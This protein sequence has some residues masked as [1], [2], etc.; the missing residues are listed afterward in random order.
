[1]SILIQNG[2]LVLPTGP[3]QADL[4]VA[5]G[6]IAELGPGL[7]PGASRVIDA[8]ERLVFPGFI[9]T[10]THFEMN[11]GFPNE[12]ADDWYTGTRAALA[13]GTTTVLDFAEPER[14]A[15]LASALETW[16]G[17]ADGA[18]CCNYGFHMTVK[19]WSP[20]I[21][22]EL[23]EMTA[24]GVTSYKV[25]LA[26][27]NLRL[28]DAAAY[29]VVKAVGAEGGVVGCHCENGD[30]VTEGIRAQQ[31]AGNLS[32]AA[33][34]LSRPPAVEAEAVGRWLT[35]AELAGCPVNI[36]H[37]STLRGLEAV[38]AARTRGQRLYV[39]TCPQYLLLDERSYRLPG[40]ESAKFVLSPPLRAQENCA[41]LWD[42]LEA[43][44]ID[45][46][47]TDHCSFRFHGAKELGREDFSKIPNG[48]PGVE[49]RP[50]LM[51]TYGVAAGRITAVDMARLLAENP[52]RLFWMYPQKGVLAVGS[53]AD[54]VIFDPNDTGRIT[55]ETQYQNVDY[56]PYEGMALRG[57]VDTVLL[58]G[59][60][61]VEGGRV[62]LE[63][64][65]RYV[66][67]GPSGFWR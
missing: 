67:R 18:A 13:G 31:A 66:S 45:T 29:E 6:R 37:L 53:D 62:L 61:A 52:A 59:E 27:D 36:V 12:T 15:T 5:G 19:D 41:A 33:H 3:I 50:S 1:M 65:G 4:R 11:K 30:L 64:R 47:G 46:I 57:R 49:H 14:G 56:T 58:G 63:R 8:Q 48:I 42:A 60:V 26:Y 51:Y 44:E 2:I 38:R 40:F 35:I 43:G 54:L 32:P 17:R 34:P 7:A 24:A 10:H 20:S 9:D 55:A 28:S 22:S 23:R 21:R 25:Y 39:E 16:H